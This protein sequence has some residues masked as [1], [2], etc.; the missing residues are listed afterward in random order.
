MCDDK[1]WRGPR[2]VWMV[3]KLRAEGVVSGVDKWMRMND[4][5]QV[6]MYLC[7]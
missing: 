4:G 6:C 1:L 2:C 7:R 3:E 5:G